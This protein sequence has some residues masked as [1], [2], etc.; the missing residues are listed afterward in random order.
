MQLKNQKR[1]RNHILILTSDAVDAKVKQIRIRSWVAQLLV[2]V[3]CILLGFIAGY[4]IYQ[5]G[6]KNSIWDTANESVKTMKQVNQQLVQQNQQLQNR[7]TDLENQVQLLSNTVNQ[8]VKDED[9]MMEHLKASQ[10]P[11]AL[12]INGSASVE[13]KNDEEPMCLFKVSQGTLIVNTAEGVV[14]E[15]KED[16]TY[17]TCITVDHQNGYVTIYRIGS[18]SMVKE[19]DYIYQG[20]TL[21]IVSE[22][23]SILAYQVK[24]NGVFIDPMSLVEISG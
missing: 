14:T 10:T 11:T 8:K 17:G 13:V 6:Y 12:P 1:M 3:F 22:K 23:E 20:T 7:V 19:G 18:E 15:V 4:I 24:L 2:V 21:Y 9:T 16:E 5:E